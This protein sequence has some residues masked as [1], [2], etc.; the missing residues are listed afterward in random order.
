MKSKA[1]RYM[2]RAIALV[3]AGWWTVFGLLAGIG[4]GGGLEGI[5]LHT[6]MPGLIFLGVALLAWRWERAGGALL[7]LTGLVTLPIFGYA[8][9][10]QGFVLLALPPLLAGLL[11]LLDS[12]T[13][14]R[15]TGQ[16]GAPG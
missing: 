4:E 1:M 10:P 6:L 8:Q 2:A 3:W 12:W 5:F 7:V 11:Y 9:T 14:R 13:M 16:S 15:P